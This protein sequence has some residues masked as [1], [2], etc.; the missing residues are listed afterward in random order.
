VRHFKDP[1]AEK[2]KVFL[3]AENLLQTVMAEAEKN[4]ATARQLAADLDEEQL[5][6]KPAPDRWSM[7][8]CLAHL[9]VGT[10]EFEPYFRKALDEKRMAANPRY[11]PTLLGGLLIR[12]LL[13]QTTRRMSAPK[14]FHPSASAIKDSLKNFLAQQDAFLDFVRR[15]EGIDYNRTRLRSPVTP[16]VRYSLADAYVLTVVHGQRHLA[17]ARRV[18]EMP[19]FPRR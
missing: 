19:E 6:W 14:I 13:P 17:Q 11:R 2:M 12:Q 7:A 16:L 10:A 18:R 1:D 8:Q 15:T 9:T 3:E 4:S 5:N